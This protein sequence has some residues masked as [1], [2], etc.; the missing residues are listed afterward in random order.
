MKKRLLM[1]AAFT[2]MT[3]LLVNAQ[4]SFTPV[5]TPDN[6]ILCPGATDTL[7][8]TEAFDT[9][10][11]YKNNAPIPGA[12]KRFLVVHQYEDAG[13]LFK[14]EVTRD[15]CTAFSKRVLVDGWAF[16]P[17]FIIESGD[18]GIYDP[19]KNALVECPE[20]TLVLTMGDPY[21]THVQW[22][23][24]SVPIPGANNKDY[25]VTKKGSYTACGAP[26]VCPDYVQCEL[27]YPINVVFDKPHATITQRNDTLFASPAKQY[28][29]FFYGRK[30]PGAN[31]NYL[32]PQRNGSYTVAISDKYTCND[33]SDPYVFSGSGVNA[34]SV[35]PNPV[36][37]VLHLTIRSGD[38]SRVIITD[39][40]GNQVMQLTVSGPALNASVSS[41]HTGTYRVLV[42]NSEN[43][44]IGS[45]TIFKL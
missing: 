22:Y 32:L 21:T 24:N 38:A 4:C 36:H 15:G 35:S 23:N 9:Y 2:G 28:Q 27:V 37:D 17:P 19:Y 1:L 34:V 26:A 16:L 29:W 18:V 40:F 45:A 8:T 20:D 39:M 33:L 10:Q 13:S 41:L 3:S 12:T 11:W 7:Y 6:P 25:L 43:Q 42:M 14:V 31:S 44:L 5:I 30:I